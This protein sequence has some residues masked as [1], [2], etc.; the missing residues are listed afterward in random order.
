MP[1]KMDSSNGEVM[2][3]KE[4]NYK[5]E[6]RK[7]FNIG[8]WSLIYVLLLNMHT[9]DVDASVVWDIENNLN[10]RVNELG[11]ELT[12]ANNLQRQELIQSVCDS[13]DYNDTD[14]LLSNVPDDQLEH[15]LIDPK[16]KFLYCYVP[17]VSVFDLK[18]N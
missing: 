14:S 7:Y 3:G 2:F 12:Q 13:M 9:V 8:L 1:T 16:R 15:L 6:F 17:K 4:I 5:K 11:F 18:K 10:M